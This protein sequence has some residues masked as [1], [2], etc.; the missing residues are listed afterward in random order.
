MDIKAGIQAAIFLSV[1]GAGFSIWVGLNQIRTARGLTFYRLRQKQMSRGWRL[2]WTGL[3]LTIFVFLIGKFGEPVVYRYFPPTPTIAPTATITLTPTI[4][5]VPTIT[6]TPTITETPSVTD[7]PTPT[8]TPFIP[9]VIEALSESDVEA[10]PD[11]VFSPLQF[12]TVM[13]NYQAVSPATYFLNPIDPIFAVYSYNNMLP[14]V[15]VTELWYR[16]GELVHYNTFPWDGTTGGL[17]FAECNYTLCDGWESG[18]Y[19]LQVFVGND[20]KVVGLFSVDGEPLTAT[21]TLT[22]SPTLEPTETPSP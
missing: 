12:S 19:Q 18:E 17:G 14:G 10:N 6:L 22:P 1:I 21:P 3:V 7:T 2:L 5:L 16:N 8:S 20:W 9:P 11:A 4:T 15:Q 13:E